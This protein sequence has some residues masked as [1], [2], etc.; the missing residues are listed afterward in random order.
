VSDTL[1]VGII[2]TGGIAAAHAKGIHEMGA[3]VDFVGGMD[4]D[5]ARI[6]AFRRKHGISA[7]YTNVSAMLE[8]Q[9]PDLVTICTPPATHAEL[10]IQCMRSGASVLCEKP[11]CASLAEMDDIA[12]AEQETGN[13]CSFVF[14][15]R[16]GSAV[17][18]LR[19]LM[20]DGVFGKPLVVLCQ[21]MWYRDHAYY[22]VPW[23]GSWADEVGGPTIGHGIHAIDLTL[24]LHGG[25]RSVQAGIR[26]LDRDIETE[27]ASIAIV[28]FGNGAFGSV[29]TSVLSPRQESYLR[30]DFQK[31]TVELSHLYSYDNTNWTCTPLHGDVRVGAAWDDFPGDDRSSHTLQIRETVKALLTGKNPPNKVADVRQTMEFVTALYQSAITHEPVFSGTIDSASPFYKQ[32]HGPDAVWMPQER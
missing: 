22:E 10:A 20:A 28:E 2:G 5:P 16:F 18:H 6:D 1:R 21:T 8:E 26:R 31:A 4:I 27:D 9:R 14:Q 7:G 17:K 30:F 15:W 19:N 32:L 13:H 12:A 23:R 11:P 24:W 25:W 3:N 29:V